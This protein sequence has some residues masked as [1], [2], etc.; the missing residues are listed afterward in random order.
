LFTFY[1]SLQRQNQFFYP[2]VTTLF[3]LSGVTVA[4]D[5]RITF[6]SKHKKYQPVVG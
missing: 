1:F 5:L 3:G 6:P 2:K 4:G